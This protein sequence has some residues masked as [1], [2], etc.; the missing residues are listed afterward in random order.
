MTL[1]TRKQRFLRA[2][3]IDA[4]DAN[5]KEQAISNCLRAAFGRNPT[6][7]VPTQGRKS[8][9]NAFGNE[10]RTRS[11]KYQDGIT[12]DAHIRIIESIA[13][14]LSERYGSILQNE[15]LRIGTVQ[16]A[17]NLYLKI[18]WCIDPNWATPPHC[19][20]DR[21]VL[22]AAHL[23]GNWTQLDTIEEYKDWVSKLRTY[24]LSTGYSSLAE[25]ELYIWN[26]S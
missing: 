5:A 16:K 25:W 19:P 10:L 11:K 9:H 22:R 4:N 12:E 15:C 1:Q 8:F 23:Y 14:D 13:N 26:H 17:L 24:A 20:I 3:N 6:Y 2:V 18:I 7:T 21:I